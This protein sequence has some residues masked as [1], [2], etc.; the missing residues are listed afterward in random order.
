MPSDGAS[1][2]HDEDGDD[3]KMMKCSTWKRRKREKNPM[4]TKAKVLLR[5]FGFCDQDTIEGVITFRID[6]RTIKRGI[7]WLSGYQVSLGV[8]I[9]VHAFR[10]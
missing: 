8:I 3:H 10:T 7:L 5:V 2:D 4:E 9:H 1:D 6:S